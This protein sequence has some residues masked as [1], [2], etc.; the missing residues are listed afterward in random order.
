MKSLLVNLAALI[1]STALFFA[2]ELGGLSADLAFFFAF[3]MIACYAG[4][5][6]VVREGMELRAAVADMLTRPASYPRR[7]A[8]WAY[9]GCSAVLGLVM[10]QSV[11]T[12]LV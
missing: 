7:T 8:Y 9:V 1:A 6:L 11:V 3:T 4:Y 2:Y 5:Q 12:E 10:L